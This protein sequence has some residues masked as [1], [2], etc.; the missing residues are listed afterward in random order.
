MPA[1]VLLCDD[2]IHILRA[3]EFKLKRPATTRYRR[4]RPGGLGDHPGRQ[5]R[6]RDHRL[7]DAAAGGLG[8]VRRVRSDARDAALP[9]SCSPPRASNWTTTSWREWNVVAVIAKPFSPRNLAERVDQVLAAAV[10]E[11]RPQPSDR[12]R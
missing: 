2:E 12:E 4:R 10:A 7:P 8:L 1:T 9:V 3:A 11:H 5:A 6:H